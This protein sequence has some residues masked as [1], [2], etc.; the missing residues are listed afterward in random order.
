[1]LALHRV[2]VATDFEPAADAAV[3]YARELA[4]SLHAELHLVHVVEDVITRLTAS[5]GAFGYY[6]DLTPV[7]RE[8]EANADARLRELLTD[9][10]VTRLHAQV[11]VLTSNV[12]A[13]A[14]AGY[15]ADDKADLIVMGTHGRKAVAHLLLGSVAERVVRTAPCPVLIVRSHEREFV[16]PDAVS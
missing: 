12:P 2:I 5:T 14:I 11:A 3:R 15:A 9:E 16:V 13:Q 6:G 10:D 1:M 4:R 7:Q 8:I